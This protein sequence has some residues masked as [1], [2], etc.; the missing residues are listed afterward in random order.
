MIIKINHTH[1][2]A[3]SMLKKYVCNVIYHKEMELMNTC[4]KKKKKQVEKTIVKIIAKI[5][6]GHC[7][8]T[9]KTFY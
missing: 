8:K 4:K 2:L 3:Q 6:A 1:F 7:F 5:Y 9:V